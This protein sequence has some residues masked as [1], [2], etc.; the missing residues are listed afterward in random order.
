MKSRLL[1]SDADRFARCLRDAHGYHARTVQFVEEH[2]PASLVFNVGA[3]A[4]ESYLIALC[5][6]FKVMPTI[7][8]F[9]GLLEEAEDM[10][11]FNPE[12]SKAITDLDDIFGIC[13]VENYYHGVPQQDDADKVVFIC[14]ELQK[15]LSAVSSVPV[16]S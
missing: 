10:V 14:D 15:M 3:I 6:W 5:S 12:L 4:I 13:S 1:E 11:A 16:N 9:S 8:N 2:R 7:H